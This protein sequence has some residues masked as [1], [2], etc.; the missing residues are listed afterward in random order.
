MSQFLPRKIKKKSSDALAGIKKSFQ[1]L[2]KC[3]SRARRGSNVSWLS[4][5]HTVAAAIAK[6]LVPMTVFVRCT[7]SFMVSADRK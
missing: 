4:L 3:L 7:T 5:F 1:F 6:A 2:C